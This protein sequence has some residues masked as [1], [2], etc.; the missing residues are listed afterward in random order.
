MSFYI[1]DGL[2]SLV[3]CFVEFTSNMPCCDSVFHLHPNVIY[4]VVQLSPLSLLLFIK[5]ASMHDNT[6][7]LHYKPVCRKCTGIS[8]Q[9]QRWLFRFG[10]LKH[11]TPCFMAELTLLF[12]RTMPLHK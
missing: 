1:L 12:F 5:Q 4:I 2:A 8:K 6:Q 11:I 9:L 3:T 10:L 7:H